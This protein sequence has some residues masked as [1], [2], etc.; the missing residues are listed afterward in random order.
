ML[1]QMIV[2][3]D[4]V[5]TTRVSLVFVRLKSYW[6]CKNRGDSKTTEDPKI[7]TRESFVRAETEFVLEGNVY[8]LFQKMADILVLFCF[9]ANCKVYE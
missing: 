9:L 2:G 6:P 3:Q 7:M 8:P 1:S 4:C 5:A